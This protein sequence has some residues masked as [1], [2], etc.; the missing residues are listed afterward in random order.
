MESMNVE[1]ECNI[2]GCKLKKC[3]LGRHQKSRK[4]KEKLNEGK[5][6][7][8]QQLKEEIKQLKDMVLTINQK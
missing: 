2:C 1:V 4:C 3:R 6:K 5:L 7:E 8:I